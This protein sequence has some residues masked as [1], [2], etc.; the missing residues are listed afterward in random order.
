MKKDMKKDGNAKFCALQI[1]IRELPPVGIK[2]MK[3]EHVKNLLNALVAGVKPYMGE[4]SVWSSSTPVGHG[5]FGEEIKLLKLEY[6]FDGFQAVLEIIM[7]TTTHLKKNL[8]VV[9]HSLNCDENFLLYNNERIKV[10]FDNAPNLV[11]KISNIIGKFCAE[12]GNKTKFKEIAEHTVFS[13]VPVLLGTEKELKEIE[14]QFNEQ[15]KKL[16]EMFFMKV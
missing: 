5:N 3:E 1:G 12:N 14:K 11:E 8:L 13:A 6:V 16:D 4:K 7:V 10:F 15:E 9:K 2:E